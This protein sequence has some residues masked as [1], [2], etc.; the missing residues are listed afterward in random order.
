M[1]TTSLW[2]RRLLQRLQASGLV[3]STLHGLVRL[4]NLVKQCYA[5]ARSRQDMRPRGGE[6]GACQGRR[7]SGEAS[8]ARGEGPMSIIY[9]SK[10]PATLSASNYLEQARNSMFLSPEDSRPASR[11]ASRPTSAHY[12]KESDEDDVYPISVQTASSSQPS[13]SGSRLSIN[14][15][16]YQTQAS[17]YGDHL[18]PSSRPSSRASVRVSN[19]LSAYITAEDSHRRRG[20]SKSRAR[21]PGRTPASSRPRPG[22]VVSIH[23]EKASLRSRS[24][25]ALPAGSPPQAVPHLP[26]NRPRRKQKMYPVVQTHR[27]DRGTKL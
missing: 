6:G 19:R 3:R 27:Y 25:A 17:V 4:F 13:R 15:H 1:S 20:R 8:S 21:S 11:P 2:I 24:N 16:Q 23:G 14:S 18:A 9:T 7:L 26:A 5:W 10:E 12:Q 22:S